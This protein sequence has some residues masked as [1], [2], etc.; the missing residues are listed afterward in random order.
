LTA[1]LSLSTFGYPGRLRRGKREPMYLHI[2]V[3]NLDVR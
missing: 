2:F 1:S 3:N